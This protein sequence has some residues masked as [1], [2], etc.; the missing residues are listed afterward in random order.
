ME[1]IETHSLSMALQAPELSIGTAPGG[2]SALAQMYRSL[3]T[4]LLRFARLRIGAA[5]A[6]DLVQ[7]AFISAKRA[8]ADKPAE[9]LRPLLYT[10]LRNLTRDYLKSGYVKH[11][12]Q[13]TDIGDAE[14][15]LACRRTLSP[16]QQLMDSQI[17]VVAQAALGKLKPRQREA[18]ELHRLEGLTHNAIAERLGVSPRTV[19]SDIANALGAVS[20]ALLKSGLPRND[21]A[22]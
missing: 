9:E 21:R 18:L 15:R 3:H 13:S 1:K 2:P 10:I 14:E 7:E 16:E 20:K 8:Y 5:D 17:L 6:E 4:E 11:R 12:R 22:K 19:R